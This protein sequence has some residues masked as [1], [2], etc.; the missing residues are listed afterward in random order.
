MA[1]NNEFQQNLTMYMET[2]HPIIYVNHYDFNAIDAAIKS[3]ANGYAM[4]V[5]RDLDK[6]SKKTC[7]LM[8][9]K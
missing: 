8:K 3:I 9:N 2:L 1:I 6:K 7:S 4:Y 5:K